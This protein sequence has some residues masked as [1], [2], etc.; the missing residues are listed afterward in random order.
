MPGA[1]T[2][3]VQQGSDVSLLSWNVGGLSN[4]ILDELFIWLSL[5]TALQYQDHLT[6]G[7][8]LAVQ[9]RVGK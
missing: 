4:A 6:S 7:D 2:P 1:A 3:L 9:L 5:P 8:S